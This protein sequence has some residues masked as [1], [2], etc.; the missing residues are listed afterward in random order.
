MNSEDKEIKSKFLYE[1]SR[2]E[3]S[4]FS[5]NKIDNVDD[6]LDTFS[7]ESMSILEAYYLKNNCFLEEDYILN[8]TNK[9]K[10]KKISIV[11]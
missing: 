8:N 6:I 10:D 1:W 4:I 9:I 11:H 7:Y 3:M 5:I 2:Y